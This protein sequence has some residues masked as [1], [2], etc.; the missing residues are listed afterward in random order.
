MLATIGVGNSAT[1]PFVKIPFYRNPDHTIVVPY[2]KY[3]SYYVDNLETYEPEIAIFLERFAKSKAAFIDCGANIGIWSI[4]ASLSIG[5]ADQVVAIE[6]TDALLDVLEQNRQVSGLSFRVLPAAIWRVGG[7][8]ISF[9]IYNEHSA[10]SLK[11]SIN[12][13]GEGR[14]PVRQVS[15]TT[16]SLD[17]VYKMLMQD[18]PDLTPVIVKLDVEGAEIEALLGGLELLGRKDLMLVYEDHG[19]DKSCFLS[20]YII[21]QLGMKVYHFDA[22]VKSFNRINDISEI[23]SLK[24]DPAVGYNFF[25]T[26]ESL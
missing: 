3:W 12:S 19:K 20:D 24:V 5:N 8:T 23:R 7:E 16:I 9:N 4:Y 15:V 17:Q 22:R 11:N 6:P 21:N 10:N 26:P 18:Y 1:M 13:K 2:D 25:A 14:V